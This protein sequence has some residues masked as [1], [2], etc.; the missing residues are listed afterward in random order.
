MKSFWL[1]LKSVLKNFKFLALILVLLAYQAMI[2]AQF[3]QE[4]ARAHA[5]TIRSNDRYLSENTSW[6]KDRGSAPCLLP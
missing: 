3:H 4:E 2:I 5:Q 6:V 1:E